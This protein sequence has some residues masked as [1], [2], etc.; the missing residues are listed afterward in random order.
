MRSPEPGQ[1]GRSGSFPNPI[2]EIQSSAGSFVHRSVCKQALVAAPNICKLEARPSGIG[3]RCLFS[4]LEQRSREIVCQSTLGS[5][6]QSPIP[7]TVPRNTGADS[8]SPS[9][10]SSSVVSNAPNVG[11]SFHSHQIRFSQCA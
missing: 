9:M 11:F 10:E 2:P 3:H 7:D 5:D 1:T 4:G 6:R 8:C